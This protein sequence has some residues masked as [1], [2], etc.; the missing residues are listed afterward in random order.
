[1]DLALRLTLWG[2][3]AVLVWKLSE[4]LLLLFFAV[5]IATV[6]RGLADALATRLGASRQLML[7]AVTVVL[8]AAGC[9]IAYWIAPAVA[10]QAGD[11]I[12]RVTNQLRTFRQE[13]SHTALGHAIASRLSGSSGMEG[14]LGTYFFHI[15]G[16]TIG[17]VGS[18]LIVVVTALYLAAA[19]GMYLEGGLRLVPVRHRSLARSVALEIGRDLRHWLLGQL[20]DMLTVG[21]LA[22]IG[23]SLLGIP[24]PFALATLAGLLTVVPYFG[25]LAAGVP[26]VLVALTHGWAAAVWVAVIFLICHSVEGYVVAPLVQRHMVRIPPVIVIGSLTVGATLFGAIGI[27]LATP[28][29]V[30]IMVLVRRVY[31]EHVLGDRAVGA[32]PPVVT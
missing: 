17:G 30:A 7:A 10:G 5:L 25:A 28:L 16:S 29:A 20:V 19:S 18:L 26:G 1:M 22:A 6:L 13:Y 27:V 31:V 12:S 15:L 3:A 2:A 4:V 24:V 23:L 9:G 14:R 32:S 21:G 8:V 11:L